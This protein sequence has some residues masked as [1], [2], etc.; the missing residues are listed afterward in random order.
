M[1]GIFLW[2]DAQINRIGYWSAFI[3]LVWGVLSW[4]ASRLAWLQAYGWPEAILVG[5]GATCAVV[6]CV[7]SGLAAWRYFRP[8]ARQPDNPP[9]TM[10]KNSLF[11]TELG[12]IEERL[13]AA[14]VRI[15]RHGNDIHNR[16]LAD[17]D[18][19]AMIDGF[20]AQNEEITKQVSDLKAAIAYE[21]RR[22]AE[23]YDILRRAMRARD[24][25][26]MLKT[27]DLKL[28]AL[29]EKLLVASEAD[30]P[31]DRAWADDFTL[32]KTH[33][34]EIDNMVSFLDETHKRFL[35]VR[36]RDYEEGGPKVPPHILGEQDINA[37]R[38]K[39]VW[40]AHNR[41]KRARDGLFGY[42]SAKANEF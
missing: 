9:T 13:S 27:V 31:N 20:K 8:L 5:L 24:A 36:L 38:F 12:K 4:I 21:R 26:V 37:T 1:R 34:D 28:V 35:D 19:G 32:W 6:L 3:L 33:L 17:R 39:T 14:E 25:E 42:L 29:A 22:S 30:Y 18:H 10:T 11:E 7:S 41:Y 40:I 16:I 15:K 2:L 23:G